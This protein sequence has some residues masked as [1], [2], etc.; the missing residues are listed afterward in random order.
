MDDGYSKAPSTADLDN[1]EVRAAGITGCN[2][3]S[4]RNSRN[5]ISLVWLMFHEGDCCSKAFLH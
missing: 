3:G 2:L 5:L 4:R 1:L